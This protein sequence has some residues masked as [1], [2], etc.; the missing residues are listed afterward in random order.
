MILF[1]VKKIT[2]FSMISHYE[3]TSESILKIN[4]SF[5]CYDK[6]PFI[7]YHRFKIWPIIREKMAGEATFLESTKT[8]ISEISKV[9]YRL[10]LFTRLSNCI[11][12]TV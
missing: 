5:E 10:K 4:S 9:K 2:F 6:C 11:K 12:M 8:A 1:K 3:K 7:C